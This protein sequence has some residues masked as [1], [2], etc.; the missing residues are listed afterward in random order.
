M[1]LHL[2]DD[3]GVELTN[4]CNWALTQFT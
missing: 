2:K 3:L 1:N 4:W